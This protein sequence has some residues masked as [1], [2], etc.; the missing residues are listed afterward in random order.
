MKLMLLTADITAAALADSTGVDRI[1]YDLETMHKE[2]RQKGRNTLIS[3]NKI[4]N[5]HKIKSCLKQAELLV[6][7]NPHHPDSC[8]EIDTA[9]AQGA[10]IIMM[11]MITSA[12]Q[13]EE[14]V[15]MVDGRAKVC[16]LLETAQTV[17]RIDSILDV[18]GVDE[19][20]LG[21]NDMHISFGLDFMFELLSGGIVEYMAGK[22]RTKKIPFGFGGL[23]RIGEG[24]LPAEYI[25]GE[26]F[27]LGSTSVILSRT[28][29]NEVGEKREFDF[30]AEIQ[31]IRD[32]EAMTNKWTVAQF[33]E[34]SLRTKQIVNTICS[35]MY[36]R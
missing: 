4:E 18:E 11:P 14:L 32:H 8:T 1:F 23:A 21:L 3:A 20:Y 5:I 25:L 33:E 35:K 15:Q 19:F 6:R 13:V 27:R 10:D 16:P 2:E 28:F 31:K 24:L 22:M 12:Y 36:E 17:A 30:V 7:I 34:N 29:R 26:H 9:I